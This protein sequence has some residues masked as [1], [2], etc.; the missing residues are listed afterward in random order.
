M[1]QYN[2]TAYYNSVKLFDFVSAKY[3]AAAAWYDGK[4]NAE[5][6]VEKYIEEFNE[7]LYSVRKGKEV[8]E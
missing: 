3:S 7:N 1:K 8:E 6:I 5:K 2:W 4:V